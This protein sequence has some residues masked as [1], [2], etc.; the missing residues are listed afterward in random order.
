MQDYHNL[1]RFIWA[2]I[3]ILIAYV[4]VTIAVTSLSRT[5]RLEEAKYILQQCLKNDGVIVADYLGFIAC[6]RRNPNV[7]SK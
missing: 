5:A 1:N 4:V 7:T 6:I 3:G 2:V